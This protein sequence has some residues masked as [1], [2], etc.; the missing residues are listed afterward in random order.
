ME[1]REA[2]PA[3]AEATQRVAHA[4]WHAAHAPIIGA[5][6]V[7]ELLSEW[8]DR[9]ELKATIQRDNTTM[10]LAIEA[11]EEEVIGFAEGG[12]SE[13]GPADAVVWRIYVHPERWGNG[14][15]T[16]LLTRLF[17]ALRAEDCDSVWLAVMAENDVARGFY[18]KHGFETYQART[19]EHVGHEVE[20]R[21]LVREL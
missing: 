15:G 17:D 3:D 19:V 14:A 1:F 16:E 20:D 7:E 9:E 4:A 18:E 6:A 21:V 5:D 8:Y 12:P 11:E 10:F 2:T 13:E